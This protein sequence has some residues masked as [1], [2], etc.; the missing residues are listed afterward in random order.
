[1]IFITKISLLCEHVAI[2][3]DKSIHG[4]LDRF[5]DGHKDIDHVTVVIRNCRLTNGRRTLWTVTA[6]MEGVGTADSQVYGTAPICPYL[7]LHGSS[8]PSNSFFIPIAP[9]PSS[10]FSI[11][12]ISHFSYCLSLSPSST[13]SHS[14]DPPTRHT[15]RIPSP[16]DGFEVWSRKIFRHGF[17]MTMAAFK[18]IFRRF[19]SQILSQDFS[20]KESNSASIHNL[21]SYDHVQR[22]SAKHGVKDDF[23]FLWE[24]AIFRHPPNK[25]PLTDRSKILHS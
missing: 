1:M 6:V 7:S 20:V 5:R 17:C 4:H 14:I 24:H 2:D 9:I 8:F 25:N 3:D 10:L 13:L 16:F 15:P 19:K 18:S 22:V 12:S 21:Y 23:A 11:R